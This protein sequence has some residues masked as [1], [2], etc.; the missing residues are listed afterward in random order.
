LLLSQLSFLQALSLLVLAAVGAINVTTVVTLL[1]QLAGVSLD[2]TLLE[3]AMRVVTTLVFGLC[4]K[5]STSL[6]NNA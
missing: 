3:S 2:W 5:K 1:E 4:A 6:V